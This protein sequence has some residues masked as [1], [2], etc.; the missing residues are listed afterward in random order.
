M[1]SALQLAADRGGLYRG[2]KAPRAVRYIS[3]KVTMMVDST[4][5]HHCMVSRI[6]NAGG[7]N[8][9]GA[10]DFLD[11]LRTDQAAEVFSRVGFTPLR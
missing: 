4:A 5:D 6:P 3:G 2:P 9:D 11:F 8:L 1:V 7:R 10:G